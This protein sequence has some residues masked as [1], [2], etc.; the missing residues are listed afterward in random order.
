M[1]WGSVAALFLLEWNDDCGVVKPCQTA[2]KT[3]TP[4]PNCGVQIQHNN[5]TSYLGPVLRTHRA[6]RND[7]KET[8]STWLG[9]LSDRQELI[10]FLAPIF[11]SFATS[12]LLGGTHGC[13]SIL[14][15]RIMI[16]M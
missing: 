16:I 10:D 4:V 1:S 11:E 7:S 6:G 5:D 8:R 12:C 9:F 15:I 13:F 14:I 3:R 2:Q